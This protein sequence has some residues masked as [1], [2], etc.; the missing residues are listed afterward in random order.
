V[1]LALGKR[2]G[3]ALQEQLQKLKGLRGEVNGLT[4]DRELPR[5]RVE[6]ALPESNPHRR[7]QKNLGNF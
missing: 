2:F 1:D 5:I 7:S 6:H 4:A 3:T